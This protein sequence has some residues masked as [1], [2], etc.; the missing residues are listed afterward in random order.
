MVST[1]L[2][3]LESGLSYGEI[4]K[5]YPSNKHAGIIQISIHP[6]W[7]EKI[8]PA[9]TRMLD[10]ANSPLHRVQILGTPATPPG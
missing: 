9:L 3:L 5:G 8:G 2:E 7:L 4:K 6:P 10:T 1:L